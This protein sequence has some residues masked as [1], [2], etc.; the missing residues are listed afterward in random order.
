MKAKM[1]GSGWHG[2]SI[3]HSNA[4]ILGRAGGKYA[5]GKY[6]YIVRTPTREKEKGVLGREEEAQEA[7]LILKT[8]G[9]KQKNWGVKKAHL[10]DL[11]PREVNMVREANRGVI[12]PNVKKEDYRRLLLKVGFD[13]KET[14]RK[15]RLLKFRR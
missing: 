3:R 2:Q 4:R 5:S 10:E 11:T 7:N 14:E 13:R 1:M 12:N 8:A 9:V 6:L 15:L